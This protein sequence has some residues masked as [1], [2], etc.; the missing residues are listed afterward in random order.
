MRIRWQ[1]VLSLR[2][3]LRQFK[4]CSCTI[5]SPADRSSPKPQL[6]RSLS[7]GTAANISLSSSSNLS[8]AL[9]ASS[10]ATGSR[11]DSSLPSVNRPSAPVSK[12]ASSS[13]TPSRNRFER[14]QIPSLLPFGFNSHSALLLFLVFSPLHDL[15]PLESERPHDK[16]PA[17]RDFSG[18][19]SPITTSALADDY[20]GSS[21]QGLHASRESDVSRSR[22][23]Q[24][25]QQLRDS[26]AN[27]ER[28][29][30]QLE[31]ARVRARCRYKR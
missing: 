16:I 14:N 23:S 22:V 24:L 11:H 7:G 9:I 2:F 25:E 19:M 26:I 4:I 15:A 27:E 6:H 3:C 8:S 1:K 20:F 18:R 17:T 12:P 21:H 13:S 28:L 29:K 30:R 31:D 10:S 5:S